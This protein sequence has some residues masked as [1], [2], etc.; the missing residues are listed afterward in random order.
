MHNT[1]QINIIQIE[2]KEI[3]ILR[4]LLIQHTVETEIC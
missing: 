4:T 2:R 3:S 1:I